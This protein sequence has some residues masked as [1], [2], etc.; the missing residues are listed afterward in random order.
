MTFFKRATSHLSK[1]FSSLRHIY[2]KPAAGSRQ[3]VLARQDACDQVSW[4]PCR[5]SVIPSTMLR[6][7]SERQQRIWAEHSNQ[8]WLHSLPRCFTSFRM[9]SLGWS[10]AKRSRPRQAFRR[11]QGRGGRFSVWPGA[12]PAVRIM[13]TLRRSDRR[14]DC[15]M[16]HL[17]RSPEPGTMQCR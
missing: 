3:F 13:R 11:G 12:S 5:H 6:A 4:H 2:G 17:A 16:T 15:S 1:A 14:R 7:G 10:V 9:T 8:R